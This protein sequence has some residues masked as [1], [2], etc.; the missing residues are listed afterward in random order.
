[1]PDAPG[2]AG[3]PNLG[4]IGATPTQWVVPLS[5]SAPSSGGAPASYEVRIKNDSSG[6]SCSNSNATTT[7]ATGIT[8]TSTSINLSNSDRCISVRAVNANP[9]AGEWSGWRHFNAPDSDPNTPTGL[10]VNSSE[11]AS[12]NPAGSG[13][14]TGGYDVQR[15]TATFNSGNWNCGNPSGQTTVA[16]DHTSTSYSFTGLTSG[17][18][19]CVRVQGVNP[20]GE[21]NY[22]SWVMFQA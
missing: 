8:G 19:Y 12:W 3:T 16:S 10:T 15:G 6:D 11:V 13:G 7:V 9:T 14:P 5:W 17:T 2:Q 18:R 20:A 4:T 1:V 22:T 21:G